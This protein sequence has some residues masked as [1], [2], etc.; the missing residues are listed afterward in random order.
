M[1][2][3]Y[4][5]FMVFF[6]S[7]SLFSQS[8]QSDSINVLKK[9]WQGIWVISAYSYNEGQTLLPGNDEVF[10]R[11][12]PSKIIQSD[13]TIYDIS[14]IKD[15]EVNGKILTVVAFSNA[16]DKGWLV[17]E[18]SSDS[19]MLVIKKLSTNEELYRALINITSSPIEDTA[20]NEFNQMLIEVCKTGNIS[21]ANELVKKGAN[22]NYT[23]DSGRTPLMHASQYGHIEIV[24]LLLSKNADVNAFGD[25]G[26]TALFLSLNQKRD[27]NKL[28]KNKLQIMKLLIKHGA[29]VN[30]EMNAEMFG[31][32]TIMELIRINDKMVR[33]KGKQIDP[34]SIKILRSA[35]AK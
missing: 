25:G 27:E 12:E 9:E 6:A 33:N 23:D 30:A 14:L 35:G 15:I 2:N 10:C 16:G 34:E 3:L 13:D 17:Q 28:K 19:I 31:N 21:K 29:D 5:I 11:A 24:K 7:V 22:V 26:I 8:V 18:L 32:V 20:G 4:S 1:K